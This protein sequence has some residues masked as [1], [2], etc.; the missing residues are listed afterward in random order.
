MAMFLDEA[1]LGARLNHANIVTVF[2]IGAAD[3]TYFIVMEF[4]E[5]CNLKTL[6]ESFRSRGELFPIK[7]ALYIGMETCRGLSYAHEL[8][9]ENAQPLSIVHR[10]ISP[11]NILLSERG[12][13]KVTDFG[14]AKAQTQLEKNGIR[15]LSKASL[16]TSHPEATRGEQ[17]DAR[18]DIFALGIVLWEMLAGRRLFLGQ[19]DYETVK[20][21][22]Q[23]QVPD[24]RQLNPHAESELEAIMQ[25]ALANDVSARFQSAREF[26]DALA[27]YLFGKQLKI[28]S[29]D[30]A[31]LVEAAVEDKGGVAEAS[32]ATQQDQVLID[33]LIQEE[34]MRFTSLEDM[35]EP[36][37]KEPVRTGPN[38]GSVP[39]DPGGF[40]N[41]SDWFSQDDDIVGSM[42]AGEADRGLDAGWH[43]T[44][45]DEGATQPTAPIATNAARP[46]A[47]APPL[48]GPG[49]SP[50]GTKPT[51][52][53]KYVVL[54][55][56]AVLMAGLAAL[57]AVKG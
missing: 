10:D 43:E 45:L 30:I 16:A 55:A 32:P 33:R 5:G 42:D 57:W 20:L 6:I 8:K 17:V 53:A 27:G 41:L 54:V 2:D 14:L 13:V 9:D 47:P 50:T 40:E 22:Q 31:A 19:S 35:S 21:V 44:G 11:P 48:A 12:E 28:T 18:A 4:I 26:G 15:G 38:E 52:V 24:L 36:L 46:A 29:Y 23:A 51:S 3:N 7:D 49:A 1:R 56:A 37:A 39:L 34:L 25:R